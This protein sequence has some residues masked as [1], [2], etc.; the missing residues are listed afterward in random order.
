M[1]LRRLPPTHSGAARS[2]T[3]L[4]RWCSTQSGRGP[5]GKESS[6]KETTTTEGKDGGLSL[7]NTN[8]SVEKKGGFLQPSDDV[9]LEY[10][11]HALEREG[12]DKRPDAVIW[13]WDTTYS[14][15]LS[16]GK[17]NFYD[18]TDDIPKHVK[19]FWHHEYY[20]QREYFR[21]QREKRPLKEHLKTWGIVV[22]CLSVA[23]AALTLIRVWVEQPREIRELREEL[24][25]QTY[26]KVLELAAGHGQNIGAYPY[27]VH[28][29]L[30]CD[31]N[32]QQ[33]QA[34][35]YR[36]PR[37]SYP[38]Y[39]VRR[40]RSENLDI[41]ADGEFDC[42][43]DMFGLCHLHDPVKALRQM[44]RVVKP[45]GLILLLEHGSS[46][47][48]PVN[49]FLS[50]FEQR[51][52]VNTHGCKWNLPIREFLRESRLEVKELRNMHYGTT[53]YVVAYPEVLEAFKDRGAASASALATA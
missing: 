24:L 34:L 44:Q 26:G 52:K 10:A 22:A 27:A 11:R 29:V 9:V 45:S 23:G 42:V 15:I 25:Q 37:T 43:V 40:V 6:S 20:Q 18:Y 4:A 33:L 39:D 51:H 5:E 17:Q 48:P 31:S 8:S 32:A 1:W 12:R 53:Y 3:V 19:P 30:M 2:V 13:Q 46:P 16:K 21:L 38:K 14:P 35:R 36:L 28:E 47:Y 49:W 7:T 50:Y 41:F